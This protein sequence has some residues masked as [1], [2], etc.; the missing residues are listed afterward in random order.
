MFET[1]QVFLRNNKA[2]KGIFLNGHFYL[3]LIIFLS[4]SPTAEG[5]IYLMLCFKQLRQIFSS[6]KTV[7]CSHALLHGSHVATVRI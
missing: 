1:F 7:K 5:R 4:I 2:K 3:E 6:S